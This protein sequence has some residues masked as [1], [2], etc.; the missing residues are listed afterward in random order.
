M[1]KSV[2]VFEAE[3]R[4][5]KDLSDRIRG[6]SRN[7]IKPRESYIEDRYHAIDIVSGACFRLRKR[8]RNGK[9]T[10]HMHN[11][12]TMGDYP[13]IEEK[14]QISRNRFD[15]LVQQYGYPNLVIKGTRKDLWIDENY[16]CSLENSGNNLR[17]CFDQ[18]G[19]LDGVYTEA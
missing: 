16:E 13:L 17:V 5:H 10:Y 19:G 12:F 15:G 3:Y 18:V 4:I 9:A 14:R 11:K 8:T 7:W 6:I 2:L 1:S